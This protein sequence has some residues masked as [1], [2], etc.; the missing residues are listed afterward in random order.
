M[1]EIPRFYKKTVPEIDEHVICSV[2]EIDENCIYFHISEYNKDVLV[3]FKE[4]NECRGK[5][6][7][8]K[9]AKK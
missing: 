3:P 8:Y 7:K 1:I 4:L 5:K 2:K 9:I 6:A